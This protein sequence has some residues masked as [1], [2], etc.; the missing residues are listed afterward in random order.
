LRPNLEADCPS[1]P[2]SESRRDGRATSVVTP[3]PANSGHTAQHHYLA[4]QLLFG[5]SLFSR[6]HSWAE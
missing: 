4:N 2:E 6:L 5:K 3:K 1:R